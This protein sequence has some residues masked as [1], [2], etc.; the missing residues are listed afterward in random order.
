M[1]YEHAGSRVKIGVYALSV[2]V[3]SDLPHSFNYWIGF[4]EF[5]VNRASGFKALN[6]TKT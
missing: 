1:P 5:F 2:Q 4:V 3:I 6:L